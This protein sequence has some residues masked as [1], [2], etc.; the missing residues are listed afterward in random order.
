MEYYI[1]TLFMREEIKMNFGNKK[2][3]A[4]FCGVLVVVLVAGY[5]GWM[6]IAPSA[7][8]RQFPQ[9]R[10]VKMADIETMAADRGDEEKQLNARHYLG[11]LHL[12]GEHKG[13]D[14]IIGAGLYVDAAK[15]ID[16]AIPLAG[17]IGGA[18]GLKSAP[19]AI[20]DP[21]GTA[22]AVT[23]VAGAAVATAGAYKKAK[24]VT[25]AQCG[26][27]VGWLRG[28]NDADSYSISK[29]Y[30]VANAIA[31]DASESVELW[32]TA[33]ACDIA[34]GK[35]WLGQAYRYGYGVAV[36]PE[37]AADLICAAA[38]KV[39]AAQYACDEIKRR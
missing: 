34:E 4:G 24:E 22:A 5:F 15:L 37:W 21:T 28:D 38:E 14:K 27:W 7:I 16:R 25:K 1:D 8:D 19:A 3:L 12:S 13:M 30:T 39:D 33:T 17:M 32:E 11:L 6:Y 23:A 20:V 26:K 2:V 35:Y 36:N 31:G 9:F 29:G 18:V 10:W